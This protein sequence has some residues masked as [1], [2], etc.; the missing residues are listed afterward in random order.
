VVDPYKHQT[1]GAPMEQDVQDFFRDIA[2]DY[3]AHGGE[4]YVTATATRD[5]QLPD[6]SNPPV[7]N[8]VKIYAAK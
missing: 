4:G 2:T 8:I 3:A 1:K 5:G 6:S 7:M